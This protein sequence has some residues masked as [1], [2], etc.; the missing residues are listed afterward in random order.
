MCVRGWND[1]PVLHK[2]SWLWVRDQKD[3]FLLD[4]LRLFI[5]LQ[6]ITNNVEELYMGEFGTVCQLTTIIREEVDSVSSDKCN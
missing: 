3:N 1:M 2:A 4:R 5:V 6:V